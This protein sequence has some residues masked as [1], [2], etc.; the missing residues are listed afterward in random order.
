MDD[1]GVDVSLEDR[2]RKRLIAH[3]LCADCFAEGKMI[4]AETVDFQRGEQPV[5]LCLGHGFATWQ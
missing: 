3:P 1:D 4:A 5:S 2:R